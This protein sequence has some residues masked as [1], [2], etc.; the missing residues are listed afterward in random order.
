MTVSQAI[1]LSYASQDADTARRI[2]DAL[3]TQGLEVWFDQSE[4]RGGDAWDQSIRKQIKECALFVPMISANTNARG[5]GYFRLEWKLAVDRSHLM[6]DDATFFVPVML[7]DSLEPAARVPDAFRARQW[8]RLNDE[9]AFAAFAGRISKLLAGSA[10]PGKNGLEAPPMLEVEVGI[11]SASRTLRQRLPHANH[12]GYANHANHTEGSA[13]GT[14]SASTKTAANQANEG[15]WVAVLPFKY[16]GTSTDLT[17]LADGLSEEIITALSRFSYLRM[18]ARAA[19][20]HLTGDALDLRAVGHALGARYVMDGTVR[21]SGASLR[22]AVQ[23]IDT[24]SGANLWAETY[25]RH[26]TP[27]DIFA[28]QDELVPRI[29]STVADAYG[30]LPHS[31]SNTLRGRAPEQLTP[32]EAVMRSFGHYERVTAAEHALVRDCLEHAVAQAPTHSDCLAALAMMYAHEYGFGLN[33][34]PDSLQR[35]LQTATRAVEFGPAN[36]S[37]F[38]ALAMV[39]HYRAE[40]QAARHAAERAIALNPMDASTNARM[41]LVIAYGG[42]WETGCAIIERVRQFNPNHAD[43]YWAPLCFNAYRQHDYRGAL[44][45]ARNI[46]RSD[47]YNIDAMIVA[48]H[49]QLGEQE[50]A[51]KT[52]RELLAS[53]PEF[54]ARVRDLFLAR[55]LPTLLV[56]H[57]LEGLR[58]AGMEFPDEHATANDAAGLGAAI[59]PVDAIAS[60]A[61]LAFA[62]RS[63]SAD[64]EYFSDG[65]ADE[66]LNV[67]AKIKGLRVAARTSAFSFKGKQSTVEEIGRILNVATVLEGSVR[68]SGNRVRISVQLIKAQDGFQLWS[69]TYDRTL[70]D[71]FAVQDDIAQSVVKELRTTLLGEREALKEVISA[72]IIE[73]TTKRTENPEAQRL[74]LQARFYREKRRPADLARAIALSEEAVAL[75]PHYAA[76]HASLADA[77]HGMSLYGASFGSDGQTV[78]TYSARSR[79]SAERALVLDA[80]LLAPQILLSWLT[81]L[82][83]RD[84]AEAMR[85]AEFAVALAPNDAEALRTLAIRLMEDGQFAESDALYARAI[86][87]APLWLQ[88]RINYSLVAQWRGDHVEARRRV[89]DALAMDES[90]WLSYWQLGSVLTSLGEHQGAVEAVARS[91]ELRGDVDMGT[92]LRHRYADEGWAGFLEVHA[93]AS[94]ERMSRLNIAFAQ[95][96]LGRHEDAFATLEAM[97]DSYDQ[98]ASWLKCGP[99]LDPLRSD[100]RYAALVKRAGFNG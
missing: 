63:A 91:F 33:P 83:E 4:L 45:I 73:A 70:D 99:R 40:F 89:E 2:C 60:I 19:T 11:R 61:V 77:L 59:K 79:A 13:N 39:Q 57:V 28:L 31:M 44:A 47:Y 68:K 43:W 27:E 22:V 100:L 49:G 25:N 52:L 24:E 85:K 8:S 32:Y 66:L 62:N 46:K 20:Q 29:V 9:S 26:F 75:D 93:T 96:E 56:E 51:T 23:L 3:R 98:H 71:I 92:L 94:P 64:D 69:E 54:P 5:E 50:A 37:A 84:R 48:C 74:V 36:H 6:A 35:A 86:Q 58:K 14:L 76:A 95:V 1:F 15:F 16:R 78:L 30:V 55:G 65:L 90:Y 80:N 53:N 21:Q 81:A 82:V 88:V 87:L 18:I 12:A 42:D 97:V 34:R 67:L 72:E 7:D 38:N 10:S 17:G 41:G